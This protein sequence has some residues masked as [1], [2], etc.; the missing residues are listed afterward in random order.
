MQLLSF[1][2]VSPWRN[3]FEVWQKK[4]VIF[5]RAVLPEVFLVSFQLLMARILLVEDDEDNISLLT[6]L[7]E[8][9]GHDLSIATDGETAVL[10][11]REEMPELILMDLELPPRPDGQPDPN[12]GLEATRRIKADPVT[13][14]IPVIALT[15]H[16]MAQHQ[17]KIAAAGCDALQE[18]PIYPF[19]NLLIKID[20]FTCRD[21]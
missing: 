11:A 6:R 13:A 2:S 12:A 7:L 20:Q 17:E 8:H 14:G 21:V 18:K 3:S 10:Q 5:S 15:A 9:H 16:T 4:M 1:T 19:E